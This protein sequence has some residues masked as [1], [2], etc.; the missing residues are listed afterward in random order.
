[1]ISVTTD[2]RLFR[3]TIIAWLS[4]STG[5]PVTRVIWGDQAA[6]RPER[7]YAMVLFP[8]RGV[9]TGIDENTM[10]FNIATQAIERVTSGPRL[11]TAQ[12][13][14]YTAAATDIDTLEAGDLL[15]NAL[16]MMDTESIRE[17]MRSA[18]IGVINHT[19]ILNTDEQVGDRWERRAISDVIFAYSG[20]SFDDGD[21]GT[22]NWIE[23]VDIPSTVPATESTPPTADYGENL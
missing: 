22:G 14:I 13:E 10:N 11:I 8:T 23:T 5:I 18:K 3:R 17:S 20:E 2:R 9:K 12:V 15:E 16:F 7:P 6:R 4:Q 19:A 1:M 21:G